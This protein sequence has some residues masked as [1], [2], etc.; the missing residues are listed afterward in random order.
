MSSESCHYSADGQLLTASFMDYHAPGQGLPFFN[1]SSHNT[2]S[3]NNALG[4]KGGR[5]IRL[6]R[7][8]VR[9]HQCDH[10]RVCD[11]WRRPALDLPLTQHGFGSA[12]YKSNHNGLA[13]ELAMKAT[14]GSHEDR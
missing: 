2:P 13:V 10:G 3:R 4:A 8:N 5:R 11:R 7:R 1:R 6:Y 14:H 12:S 9:M